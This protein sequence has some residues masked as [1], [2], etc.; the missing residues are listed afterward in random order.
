MGATP[1]HKF[2]NTEQARY[3]QTRTHAHQLFVAKKAITP[4]RADTVVGATP[5]HK[6]DNTERARYKQIRTRAHL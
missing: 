6:F 4:K 1:Q 5:Q 2:D 3:K